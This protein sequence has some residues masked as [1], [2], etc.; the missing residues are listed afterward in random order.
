MPSLK[1]QI[2]PIANGFVVSQSS[3]PTQSS[4]SKNHGASLAAIAPILQGIFTPDVTTAVNAITATLPAGVSFV[5]TKV[6]SIEQIGNGY[7][8]SQGASMPGPSSST[9]ASSVYAADLPTTLGLLAV[10]YPAA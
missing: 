1:V 7:L 5:A 2:S 6:T 8:L 10:I 3:A 9:S 4:A